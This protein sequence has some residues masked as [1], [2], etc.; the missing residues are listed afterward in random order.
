MTRF[1]ELPTNIQRH[2]ESITESSGLPPGEDSLAR[3]TANWLEKRRLF[4]EQTDL[5]ELGALD[6]LGAEDPRAALALTYSGSL[7]SLGVREEESGSDRAG[8]RFEYASISLRADVPSLVREEGVELGGPLRRDAPAQFRGSSIEKTSPILQIAACGPEVSA[9]DQEQRIREATIFLTNGFV[10]LNRSLTLPQGELDHFTTKAMVQYVARKNGITQTLARQVIDDYLMTAE[11][12][13]L[14]G[15]RV[16]L[17]RLGRL[18]L[19]TRAAQKARMGRNPATGE[20]MVIPA[21]PETAVPKVSFSKH[22]RERAAS[23]GAVANA[24]EDQ[25]E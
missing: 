23:A 17:G 2:L 5:L 13:A 9:S 21:K 16:P 22:L 8:R 7:V 12:G 6:E 18:F 19:G 1:E 11:A 3:I 20:D 14:L 10:K 15:E 24:D 4:E 25:E